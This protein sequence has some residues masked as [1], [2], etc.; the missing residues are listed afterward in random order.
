M[1][2][3]KSTSSGGSAVAIA[4]VRN[5]D[6]Y[7]THHINLQLSLGNIWEHPGFNDEIWIRIGVSL[8]VKLLNC[9][10][11]ICEFSFKV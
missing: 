9:F 7:I 11:R 1:T 8:F 3:N 10:D 2:L 5:L 6:E 4:R